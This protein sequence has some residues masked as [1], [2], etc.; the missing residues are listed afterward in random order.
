VSLSI[1]AQC[2]RRSLKFQRYN[3]VKFISTWEKDASEMFIYRRGCKFDDVSRS[4]R[5][6]A[7]LKLTA[8][9]WL[10][11]NRIQQGMD[12]LEDIYGS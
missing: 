11:N 6:T 7:Q 9:F 3:H 8:S 5:P 12:T 2:S 1:F 10:A 4:L